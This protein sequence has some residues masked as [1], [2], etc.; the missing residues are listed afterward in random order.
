M[1]VPIQYALSHP[2]RWG[3]DLPRLDLASVG[4]LT[5][6]PVNLARY[7]A[8][9]LARE[10]SRLGGTYPAVLVGADEVAVESFLD[11]R[12]PFTDIPVVIEE[13]LASHKSTTSPNLDGIIDAD[14]W[15]RGMAERL[16]FARIG[17]P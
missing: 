15:A 3:N 11:G 8:L 9:T 1:R 6:G 12:I 4:T 17:T 16:V 2:D 14:R 13:T 5:F 10:A 7:P